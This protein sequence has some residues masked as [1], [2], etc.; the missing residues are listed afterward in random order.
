M[1]DRNVLLI[2]RYMDEHLR[3]PD[4]KWPK[5]EFELH[6]Y[7]R[8]AANEILERFMEEAMKLP[9]HITGIESQSPAEIIETF[10]HELDYY[11]DESKTI[12]GQ[13]MFSIARDEARSILDLFL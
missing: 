13:L 6:T 11:S 1:D 12:R 8:W 2:Q 7:Q 4:I 3:N 5:S 10:M 9:P